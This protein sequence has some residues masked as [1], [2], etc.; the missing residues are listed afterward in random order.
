M[1]YCSIAYF[2]PAECFARRHST[3]RYR[4]RLEISGRMF[5]PNSDVRVCLLFERA[6]AK[7]YSMHSEAAELTVK[8]DFIAQFVGH[9]V[10]LLFKRLVCFLKVVV[11]L[12]S[13][14]KFWQNERKR[15][16]N[17]CRRRRYLFFWRTRSI[18]RPTTTDGNRL[19][20]LVKSAAG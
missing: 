3:N 13:K 12:K 19:S 11:L 6:R 1:F 2:R 16:Q 20:V 10:Q 7:R 14:L 17:A 15:T 4:C 5:G 8:N 18:E 9:D